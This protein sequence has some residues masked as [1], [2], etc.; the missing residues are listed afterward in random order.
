MQLLLLTNQNSAFIYTVA[1]VI[2]NSRGKAQMMSFRFR[3]QKQTFNIK[4]S[5]L[6]PWGILTVFLSS[7]MIIFFQL[8]ISFF[9]LLSMSYEPPFTI[10]FCAH[11]E[12]MKNKRQATPDTMTHQSNTPMDSLSL[13]YKRQTPDDP[14]K[15]PDHILQAVSITE[16]TSTGPGIEPSRR[17]NIH[18][19]ANARG[20]ISSS[21]HLEKHKE[22]CHFSNSLPFCSSKWNGVCFT[23]IIVAG[24]S[25]Q[26][27]GKIFFA[28]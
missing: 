17:S 14:Q 1:S 2:L 23:S 9:F 7:V 3:K 27:P 4:L 13:L 6:A 25:L 19:K 22:I 26:P 11:M 16:P 18:P 5:R 12:E 15:A 8:G 21:T 24:L 20:L 28:Q 10:K